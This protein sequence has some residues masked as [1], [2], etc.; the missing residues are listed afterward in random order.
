MFAN[1]ALPVA[2]VSQT[3]R[4]PMEVPFPVICTSDTVISLAVVVIAPLAWIP[5]KDPV[6]ARLAIVAPAAPG[7]TATI[8]AP[9]GLLSSGVTP[10]L[11]FRLIKPPQSL[12]SR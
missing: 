11:L 6:I 8:L 7:P 2:V 12:G 9:A 4:C 10:G 3:P 1:V 5:T